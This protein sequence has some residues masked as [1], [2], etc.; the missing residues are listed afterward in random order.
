[1]LGGIEIRSKVVVSISIFAIILASSAAFGWTLCDAEAA[2]TIDVFLISGQSNAAYTFRA[3]S[4]EAS[5]IGLPGTSYYFGNSTQPVMYSDWDDDAEYGIYDMVNE[6][7]SA[8]I[9][10]IEQSFATTY[11]E[12]TGHKV[13]IINVAVSGAKIIELYP[14]ADYYVWA[15]N[16]F[17]RAV[18]LLEADYL[19]DVKGLIWIQGESD[20]A[21]PIQAYKNRFVTIL[22]TMTHAESAVSYF[23]DNYAFENC[24]ISLVRQHRG[25]NTCLSQIELAAEHDNIELG[26]IICD[27]FSYDNGLMYNDDTHYNQAG[28][29]IV[30]VNLAENY[31]KFFS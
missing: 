15:Q 17:D 22:G 6:D 14:E 10:G 7:G 24:I 23:N 9:G 8:H 16:V 26:C 2:E 31:I 1:M 18:T 19:V 20:P 3:V 21:W 27:T 28:R 4:D 11:Y 25:Q 13:C 30:G 29:N 12:K 5:P